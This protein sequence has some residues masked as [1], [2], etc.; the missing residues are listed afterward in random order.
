M[1]IKPIRNEEDY[2]AALEE[3]DRL[4]AEGEDTP[5]LDKLEVLSTLIGA[6]EAEQYPAEKPH[7]VEA[8]RYYMESRGLS[9]T[10][11][12]QQIGI[13]TQRLGEILNLRRTLSITM[14]RRLVEITPIPA[15]TL[16][17]RYELKEVEPRLVE[18]TG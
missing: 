7:P 9:R 12:S 18:V 17:Q 3:L 11:F 16:L 14:I 4:M 10:E 2:D 13:T 5:N 6:Y 15:D 1:D 8:I